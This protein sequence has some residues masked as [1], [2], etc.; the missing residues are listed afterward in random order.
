MSDKTAMSSPIG[1]ADEIE[2]LA[3]IWLERR[4]REDWNERDRTELDSWLSQSP[5]H[6]VTFLRIEDVWI[7][8][9]RLR[10]L[11]RPARRD[12]QLVANKSNWPI[13]PRIAV[14]LAFLV[15][16]ISVTAVYCTTER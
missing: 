1:G 11:G 7:R 6:T 16:I 9:D 5:I 15:A 3:A 10:A 4:E 13:F 2:S 14:S 8:A 12:T